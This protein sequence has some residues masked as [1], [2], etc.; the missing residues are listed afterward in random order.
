MTD[1]TNALSGAQDA[2]AETTLETAEPADNTAAQAEDKA[3][4]AEQG[5]NP[6]DEADKAKAEAEDGDT[7]DDPDDEGKPKRNRKT[8]SERIKQLTQIRRDLE[9]ENERLKAQAER[10]SKLERPDPNKYD[11]PDEYQSDLAA[12]KVRRSSVDDLNASAQDAEARAKE[13]AARAYQERVMDF[14]AETPDFQSVAGNPALPI[15]PVMAEEIVDSDYG[16]QVQYYLGK[17][18]RM[19]AQIAALSPREQIRA[20][21]RLEARVSSPAT[22]RVTQAPQPIKPVAGTRTSAAFDPEKATVEEYIRKRNE[23]W[24]G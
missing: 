8:A 16:P 24:T 22:K 9:R 17:N 21:G 14:A 15:T 13:M 19:A 2:I 1:E 4:E 3:K 11:D 6:G 23:G 20:I 12:Y 18:P 7:A 5:A 10:S